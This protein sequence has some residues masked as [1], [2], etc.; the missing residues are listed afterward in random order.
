M[1]PDIDGLI[2]LPP[3]ANPLTPQN[4]YTTL[5]NASSTHQVQIQTAAQQLSNWEAEPGYYSSLQSILL[6]KSIPQVEVRYLAI[7]QLK[8]GI[9]KYWRKTARNAMRKDEKALIRSRCL[10][11]GINE[12]DHRLA[13]QN[14]LLVA[15]IVR[16]DFP[17]DWSDA[18]SSVAQALRETA[19]EDAGSVRLSRTILILL[20]IVKELSTA[21][22]QRSRSNLYKATPEAFTVLASVYVHK[23]NGCFAS[24][25]Q[26]DESARAVA[27]V[28]VSLLALRTLRR[29]LIAGYEHPSRNEEVHAFWEVIRLHFGEVL[30]LLGG[31]SSPQVR[32]I[33]FVEQHLVQISKI[34][35]DMVRTHPSSFP[36]LPKAIEIAQS[37]WHLISN[38]GATYGADNPNAPDTDLADDVDPWYMETLCLKALHILKACM[39]IVYSPSHT[40]KYQ[41]PQDKEE[42]KE[43]TEAIKV[44]LLEPEIIKQMSSTLVTQFFRYTVRDLQC[45]EEDPAEWEQHESGS[46]DAWE[47]SIRLAAEKLF[48]DLVKNNKDLLIPDLLERFR[49]I[50][51]PDCKDVF[52]KDSIYA[53]IGLAADVLEEKL[54]FDTFMKTTLVAD[55][56]SSELGFKIVRRRIAIILGQWI[57]VKDIDRDL[58]Y[59]IFQ[60][61]LNKEDRLNDFVVRVTAGRQ[62]DHVINTWDLQVTK[63]TP[64]AASILDCLLG[65][66]QEVELAET[67]LALLSAVN[68]IVVRLELNV[69][70]PRL[71]RSGWS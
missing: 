52:V 60:H 1:M 51:T 55:I 63:F 13:L 36:Q 14:A 21:R 62:M 56:Q 31:R 32:W 46:G 3:E 8:N 22:L 4:L 33:W 2:E 44:K 24:L 28:E 39:K 69:R 48:L 6:N 41:H 65:L 57:V 19:D 15:K 20:Y 49:A 47:F 67:K 25:K 26:G 23:F 34:H 68:S 70:L 61:L 53:A 38:F 66:I 7:I 71:A 64:F 17:H 12:A 29:L 45:W 37:Y 18:I 35:Q 59:Q 16:H 50:G 11:Y 40:F 27:N 43:S 5:V 58:V 42:R 9:D 10:E 30:A 54:D